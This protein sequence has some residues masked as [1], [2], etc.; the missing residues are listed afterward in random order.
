MVASIFTV[1]CLLRRNLCIQPAVFNSR[2]LLFN[3]KEQ[4]HYTI[5]VCTCLQL[6]SYPGF[7]SLSQLSRASLLKAAAAAMLLL[8]FWMLAMVSAEDTT[9]ISPVRSPVAR[10]P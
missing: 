7:L 8:F 9:S 1:N 5:Q 10:Q 4:N 6:M 2:R 3:K